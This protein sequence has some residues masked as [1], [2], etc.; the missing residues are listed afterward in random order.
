MA[1][2]TPRT[3]PAPV[4]IE[5]RTLGPVTKL[6]RP[7]YLVVI[8]TLGVIVLVCLVGWL[9]LAFQDKSMPDGLSVVLGT[10]VGG[11]V[12]LIADKPAC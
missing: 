1:E 8:L 9:V 4:V 3:E 6:N 12:G 5:D 10:A 7:V 11:L 2:R